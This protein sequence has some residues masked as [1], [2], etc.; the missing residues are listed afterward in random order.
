MSEKQELLDELKKIYEGDAW[1]GDSLS[2][3]L[4][5]VSADQA[6]SRPIAQAHSMWEVVLH[7]AAWS[8]TFAQRLK[9]NLIGE[10]VDGDFPAIT[11]ESSEAWEQAL[12]RL[13]A[14]HDTLIDIVLGLDE[15]TFAEKFRGRDYSLSFFLHG[16]VRHIVYHSGQLGLLKKATQ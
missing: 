11:E 10:P 3:I 15:S 8:E 14:S 7:I 16:I 9:G 2:E 13:K 5:G 1:H 6:I 12:Q 4:S